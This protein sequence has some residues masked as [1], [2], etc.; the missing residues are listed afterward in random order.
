MYNTTTLNGKNDEQQ[1]VVP[2]PLAYLTSALSA[3]AATVHYLEM[4]EDLQSGTTTV[5]F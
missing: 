3:D 1:I 4:H 2:A 5:L